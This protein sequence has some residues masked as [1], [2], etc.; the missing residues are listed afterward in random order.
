MPIP[1][2]SKAER[3]I[4]AKERIFE[5]VK[6]WIMEGQLAPGEK[7]LDATIAEYF[8]VS[9]TP[10]R[11]AIQLLEQQK[12][13]VS[14][15]GKTTL[16]TELDTDHIEQWYA[17]MQVL[18]QLGITL[19]VDRIKEK[20]MDSLRQIH[21]GL[22]EGIQKKESIFYILKQNK[23]FYDEIL[24]VARNT[25]LVDF[26]N[27]LWTHILRLEQNVLNQYDILEEF[28][29]DQEQLLEALERKD[30]FSAGMLMK[31]HWDRAVIQIRNLIAGIKE[32]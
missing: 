7:I 4:S 8:Q 10:V 9:R 3:R 6:D 1:G 30:Q 18:H 23:K 32:E 31:N 21:L 13:V 16:V 15:P 19:A 22:K 5:T 20:D 25:Y 28:A 11:E 12:L 26:C 17:P 27:T 24:L 29:Q 2:N 14:Y